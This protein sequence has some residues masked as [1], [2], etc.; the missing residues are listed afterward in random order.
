MKRLMLV[1]TLA[2]VAGAARAS[3]QNDAGCGL[4]SM[5]FKE[6]SP[7]H[8]IVAATT[9]GTSGNQTF[10]ITTGTLGCTSGGLI[11]SSKEREVFTAT[12]IRALERELAAGDGQYASALASLSGCGAKSGAFLS[13]AKTRYEKLFPNAQV[14]AAELLKNLDKEI[15]ADASLSKACVL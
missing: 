13:L 12:N 14:G 5:L 2:M 11:K 10:G 6:Q 7:V 4:G 8:Q 1:A 9:N 3:G 15:A